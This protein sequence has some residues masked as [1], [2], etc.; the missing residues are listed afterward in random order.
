MPFKDLTPHNSPAGLIG[1]SDC[2]FE[3][4]TCDYTQ[5]YYTEYFDWVLYSGSESYWGAGPD[6][7]HSTESSL[8]KDKFKN[9]Y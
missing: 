6:T 1:D 9:V 3:F 4:G 8:G 2:D 7:D 5:N